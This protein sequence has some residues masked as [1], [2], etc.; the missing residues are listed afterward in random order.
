M[1]TNSYFNPAPNE[2]IDI[3]EFYAIL[4]YE[5]NRNCKFCIERNVH[6]KGFLT[7]ENF[8]KALHF[9]KDKGLT[10][11]VLHGGEPT[12]HPQIIDFA[13]ISKSFG[14]CVKMFSNYSN[15]TVINDLNGIVDVL[16]ISYRNQNIL[17]Y[18]KDY[19]TKME[20]WTLLT[21]K[22]YPTIG[23]VDNFIEKHQKYGMEMFFTTLNPINK[24]ASE[25]QFV[26]YVEDMYANADAKDIYSFVNK[27]CIYYRN[28][29]IRLCNKRIVK[30]PK[31]NISV[32]GEIR[33]HFPRL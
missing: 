28:C 9:A 20:L 2:I 32:S 29:V 16:H 4:T 12:L 17:P 3:R 10:S 26:S 14:F 8:L 15:P 30:N 27:P 7:E 33:N 22:E 19:K 18:Q 24:W 13:K 23:H 1:L 25:N 11:I 31:F 21:E 6:Q 5:C